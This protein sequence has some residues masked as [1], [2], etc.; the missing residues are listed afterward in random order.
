MK[1]LPLLNCGLCGAPRCRNHAEDVAAGRA[2]DGD[3]VFLARERIEK[4]RS[5]YKK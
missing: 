2:Q 5:I 4:L 1:T 3:C